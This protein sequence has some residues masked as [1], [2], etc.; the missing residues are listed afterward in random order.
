MAITMTNIFIQYFRPPANNTNSEKS[1][2]TLLELN[3][4]YIPMI[5]VTSRD[6]KMRQKI[7][8]S[9]KSDWTSTTS[10]RHCRCSAVMR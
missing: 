6:F 9:L 7:H 4:V 2:S 10:W 3:A 8:G 5:N 1:Y